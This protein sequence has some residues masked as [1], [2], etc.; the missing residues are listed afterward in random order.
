[1]LLNEETLF[2]SR[3]RD[4]QR[5]AGGRG[6]LPGTR[7]G[8][9]EGDDSS[10]I[11]K[12]AEAE[13]SR[14]REVPG[15]RERKRSRRRGSRGPAVTCTRGLP[16]RRAWSS[17]RLRSAGAGRAA[18]A[19]VQAAGSGRFGYRSLFLTCS[20][21]AEACALGTCLFFSGGEVSALPFPTQLVWALTAVLTFDPG[22]SEPL[23]SQVSPEPLR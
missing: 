15:I 8:T 20:R 4:K 16:L 9:A 6:D 17:A 13:A 22:R 18:G 5:P 14:D 7:A 21:V 3:G 19:A 12:R 11:R 2:G 10:G 1:M 23:G